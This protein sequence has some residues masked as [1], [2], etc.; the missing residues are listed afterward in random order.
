MPRQPKSEARKSRRASKVRDDGPF[1][2]LVRDEVRRKPVRAARAPL[3]PLTDT[4]RRYGAA[5]L[6]S[7]VVFGIGP[8][9]T[10][11]TWYAAA[12]AADKLAAGEI[13]KIIVTRPAKEAGESLGFLKGDM[14]EKYEPYFRP[15]REALEERLGSGQVEYMIKAGII[16]ARPLA[17]MRGST[18]K[19]AWVIADEM[20]NSTIEQMKMFL[21]RIGKGATFIVNG[22]VEQNDINRRSGLEDAAKRLAHLRMVE[23]VNFTVADIVR[24]PMCQAIAE[25][26]YGK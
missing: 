23:V 9:G 14:D 4:Q 10:G 16:E 1:L 2:A 19:N 20:Q 11:K 12:L 15:V 26:Y 18:L 17:F 6:A 21:T 22:D 25:T 8:S 24:D 5:I 3:V 13:E 7:R